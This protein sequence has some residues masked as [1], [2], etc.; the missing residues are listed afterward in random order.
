MDTLPDRVLAALAR[1]GMNPKEASLKAKLSATYAR[2]LVKSKSKNPRMDHLRRF[3]AELGMTAEEL[4]FGPSSSEARAARLLRAYDAMT[5]RQQDLLV[6]FAEM[7]LA[8][9]ETVEDAGRPGQADGITT[10]G[11]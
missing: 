4:M 7:V 9:T 10:I 8:K 6:S 2:D 1:V 11:A 3:A 5:G